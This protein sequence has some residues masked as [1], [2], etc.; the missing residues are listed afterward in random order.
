MR[1][2][3]VLAIVF[4]ASVYAFKHAW[5]GVLAWTWLGLMNPHKQSWGIAVDFPVAAVV[6]GATLV[7]WVFS[8]EKR[9]DIWT[10]ASVAML[11]LIIWLVVSTPFAFYPELAQPHLVDTLKVFLMIFVAMTLINEKKQLQYLIWVIVASLGYYGVKGGVFT[12]TTGGAHRVWGPS[13]TMLE[14]N[15]ELA[16]ALIQSGGGQARYADLM[17]EPIYRLMWEWENQRLTE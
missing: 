9:M 3:L 10:P 14:G 15:N 7:S 16:L 5:A 13:G 12:I 17:R 11:L 2:I 1:D 4:G 6:G 8:R